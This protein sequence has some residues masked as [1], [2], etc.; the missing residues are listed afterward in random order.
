MTRQIINDVTGR[1]HIRNGVSK[2]D[3][4]RIVNNPISHTIQFDSPLSKIDIDLLE[5]EVFSKRPDIFLRVFG[6]HS[7]KSCDI[8][9]VK[10]IPSLRRFS[11][12]CL[13]D[14]KGIEAVAK[15]EKLEHLGVGILHQDNFDFLNDV[16][17]NLTELYL[18]QTLSKKP[19]INVIERFSNLKFLFLE[20]QQK[21]T[22]A[23]NQLAKLEKLVLRSISTADID[24]IKGLKN[25]WSVDI[26]L[27]GIKNF[28]ALKTLPQIKY[29]EL[30]QI[31][32]L[33]DLSFLS[34][35]R[36]LQ[37]L[38]VQ[39]LIQV[40][41]LPC[42]IQNTS[43]R[44][45]YLENLKGLTNLQ[46]LRN[47]PALEEFVYVSANNLE[48]EDLLPVLENPNLKSISCMFGSI[49]K[50][51]SFEQLV[52]HYHKTKYEDVDFQYK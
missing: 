48:A 51:N 34:E 25:L 4:D 3:L 37:N 39:S 47:A 13:V 9:F 45:L 5:N 28:D 29:L 30:W 52:K 20:A 26:K 12:D 44:R 19:R 2:A 10:Q 8:N 18:F 36:T 31:R 41:E 21:G 46:T 42:F 32:G 23:I 35:L 1:H 17:P 43:L 22:E 16:N 14:A 50:N 11:A 38:F 40:S 27:G 15:L 24:Y 33:S 7:E 49:R 6:H